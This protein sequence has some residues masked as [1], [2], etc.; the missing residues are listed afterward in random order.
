MSCWT[1]YVLNSISPNIYSFYIRCEDVKI[2]PTS[3]A[4]DEIAIPKE[5]QKDLVSPSVN[6]WNEDLF[7]KKKLCEL[8]SLSDDFDCLNYLKGN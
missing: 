2:S 1:G 7:K 6:V 5:L 3:I 8:L 4:L